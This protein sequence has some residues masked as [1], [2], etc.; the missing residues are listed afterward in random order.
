MP[1]PSLDASINKYL[2]AVSHLVNEKELENTKKVGL[3]G[4]F[5]KLIR[6]YILNVCLFLPLDHS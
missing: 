3:F 1:V 6:S 4:L 5:D 2:N